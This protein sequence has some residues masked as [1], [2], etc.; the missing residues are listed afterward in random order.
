[1]IRFLLTRGHE[2]TLQAVQKSQRSSAIS[3][4]NYDQLL[5]ARW[6]RQATYI[7]TD[8]DR[9]SCW[10]LE[11]VSQLYLRLKALGFNVLNNPAR[12]KTRYSLLRALHAAG[13]NDFNAYRVDEVDAIQFPAFLRKSHSHDAPLSDLINDRAGLDKAIDSAIAA[14]IPATNLLAIEF[15]AE[16]VKPGIYRKLAAFRIGN[17]IVPHISVHDT[18]WLVKHGQLGIAGE[19]LY[20][21]EFALLQSNPYA[22]HLKQ[23]FDL[24]G[25]EYGRA[26]FSFYK[27]RIQIYEINTN[28]SVAAGSAHP[29][30]VRKE[31]LLLSWNQYLQALDKIDSHGGWPVKI[32]RERGQHHRARENFFVRTRRVP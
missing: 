21:N 13:L 15:A 23:V 9:L 3:L 30:P 17:E 1:M 14:G 20:R 32:A 7:F 25:I 28:P 4:M 16:P 18:N 26:D 12:V 22:G 29:S 6:L 31:S 8:L 24:A 11:L 5:R 2:Y 10:D 19:D 27:G